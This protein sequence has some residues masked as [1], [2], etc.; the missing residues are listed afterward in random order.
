MFSFVTQHIGLLS[1]GIHNIILSWKDGGWNTV[2]TSYPLLIR[3]RGSGQCD[4]WT[5]GPFDSR[6]YEQD[7]LAVR[8]KISLQS[9]CAPLDLTNCYMLYI[10]FFF[11]FSRTL[12]GRFL[13]FSSDFRFLFLFFL[14][15]SQTYVT[16][17]TNLARETYCKS[18]NVSWPE[19]YQAK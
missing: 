11:F 4:L 1:I 8:P 3:Q 12:L 16:G 18:V 6:K 17:L 5:S 14:P 19:K 15:P 2:I 13:R 7:R 10:T 9:S